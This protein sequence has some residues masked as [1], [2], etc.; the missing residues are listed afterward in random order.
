MILRW[1][2]AHWPQTAHYTGD[3]A[4]LLLADVFHRDIGSHVDSREHDLD[5][6][7]VAR[8]L[9]AAYEAAAA[10]SNPK[11]QAGNRNPKKKC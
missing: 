3:R 10:T 1:P 5:V 11:P 6:Q 2:S 9:C 7:D 4:I 8:T